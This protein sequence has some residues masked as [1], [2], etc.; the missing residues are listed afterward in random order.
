MPGIPAFAAGRLLQKAMLA[1]CGRTDRSVRQNNYAVLRESN[2]P[3]ALVETAFI[4]N[5]EEAQLLAT[6]DFQTKAAQAI[7]EGIQNM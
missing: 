5:A 1:K 3:S 6:A 4:S 2:M 7:A